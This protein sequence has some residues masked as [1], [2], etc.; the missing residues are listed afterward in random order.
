MSAKVRY[1]PALPKAVTPGAREFLETTPNLRIDKP[2]DTA[3]L[4]QL[5]EEAVARDVE[6]ERQ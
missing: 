6:I 2:I 4:R 1:A 3:R 5:V